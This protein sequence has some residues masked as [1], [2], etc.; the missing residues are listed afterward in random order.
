MTR[1][2]RDTS[3]EH[4]SPFLWPQT[5]ERARKPAS[6]S[7]EGK[8]SV[9]ITRQPEDAGRGSTRRPAKRPTAFKK[10]RSPGVGSKHT[11]ATRQRAKKHQNQTLR[12]S[13]T[14]SENPGHAM[15]STPTCNKKFA[16]CIA[17]RSHSIDSTHF[18]KLAGFSPFS[19]G[20]PPHVFDS[21]H[22][23]PVGSHPGAR[24]KIR[25]AFRFG[26]KR[27]RRPLFTQ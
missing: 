12:R 9:C 13:V 5:I 3:C 10:T 21:G 14:R 25:A 15:V 7:N 22:E 8:V 17:H 19:K 1:I 11:D 4:G 26:G 18:V 23:V 16:C 20:C 6:Q 24:L 27:F 2:S